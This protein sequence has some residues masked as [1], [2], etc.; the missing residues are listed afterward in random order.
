MYNSHRGGSSN[1]Y[2][3]YVLQKKLI[4]WTLRPLRADEERVEAPPISLSSSPLNPTR[5]SFDDKPDLFGP[6]DPNTPKPSDVD[7]AV[8]LGFTRAAN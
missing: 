8:D 3:T 4:N 5:P 6:D 1:K 2:N 7:F